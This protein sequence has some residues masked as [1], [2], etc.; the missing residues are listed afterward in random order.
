MF[1]GLVH[2]SQTLAWSSTIGTVLGVLTIALGFF[3]LAQARRIYQGECN[4]S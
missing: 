1:A 4:W 2:V 3:S